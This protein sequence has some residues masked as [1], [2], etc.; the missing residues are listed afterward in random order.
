MCALARFSILLAFLL[1]VSIGIK[2]M[3]HSLDDV[4][5]MKGTDE[6]SIAALLNRYGFLVEA[7]EARSD[8]PLVLAAAANCHLLVMLAAPEGWHRDIPYRLASPQDQVF[9]VFDG[10]V[11]R[12]QPIWRTTLRSYWL[13]LSLRLGVAVP[14]QP[15]LGIVASPG[16]ALGNVR[17][18]ELGNRSALPV[19]RPLNAIRVAHCRQPGQ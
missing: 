4:G 8:P 2:V 9:F 13:K 18:G 12:N 3:S 14:S 16:C 19:N 1:G 17:W 15:V 10:V 11:Y 5:H 7:G 6:S